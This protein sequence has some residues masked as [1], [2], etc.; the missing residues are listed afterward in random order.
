MAERGSLQNLVQN[1]V[2]RVLPRPRTSCWLG[3]S[4]PLCRY[5]WGWVVPRG[6]YPPVVPCRLPAALPSVPAPC[7]VHCPWG[8]LSQGWDMGVWLRG[9][10]LPSWSSSCGIHVHVT[11]RRRMFDTH[12]LQWSSD[13]GYGPCQPNMATCGKVTRPGNGSVGMLVLFSVL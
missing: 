5:R 13:H 10:C 2:Q 11:R 7:L 6:Y 3:G 4:I 8:L 12:P 1:L 9:S